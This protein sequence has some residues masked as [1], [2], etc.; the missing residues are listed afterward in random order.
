VFRD[1]LRDE[2]VKTFGLPA[3][4]VIDAETIAPLDTSCALMIGK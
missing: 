1:E 4:K 2:I 3:L